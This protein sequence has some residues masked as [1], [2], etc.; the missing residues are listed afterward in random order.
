EITISNGDAI[1]G[2]V[3]EKGYVID[4]TGK[5]SAGASAN[6]KLRTNADGSEYILVTCAYADATTINV[7]LDTTKA[8]PTSA[9]NKTVK[10]NCNAD[11]SFD[12]QIFV[13]NGM[14]EVFTH[15]GQ[16]SLTDFVC[17]DVDSI[18]TS[19]TVSGGTLNVKSVVCQD[20]NSIWQ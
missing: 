7:T 20:M 10:T 4:F 6:F 3:T 15:D 17:P 8:G 13:D 14:I 2:E 16:A 5:L 9:A 19:L 1:L 18:G 11:G 12:L